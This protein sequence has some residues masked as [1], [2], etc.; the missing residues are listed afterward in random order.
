MV[1]VNV[2]R[3]WIVYSRIWPLENLHYLVLKLFVS[4]TNLKHK[5]EFKMLQF[6]LLVALRGC[7]RIRGKLH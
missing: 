4:K 6:I 5:D 2:D 7:L 3:P 1:L